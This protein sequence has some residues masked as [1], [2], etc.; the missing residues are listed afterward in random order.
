MGAISKSIAE[1]AKAWGAEVVTS[2]TV[3]RLV[4]DDAQKRIA[5]VEM[6]DGTR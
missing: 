5:G 1:A 6:Q 4:Y 2:A 3:T